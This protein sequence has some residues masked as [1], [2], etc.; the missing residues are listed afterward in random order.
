MSGVEK[1]PSKIAKS[2][3]QDFGDLY[4]RFIR[5]ALPDDHAMGYWDL[6]GCGTVSA[7]VPG[8]SGFFPWPFFR[9]H[10]VSV[11]VQRCARR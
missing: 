9:V 4:R 8:L 2:P 7:V 10:F 1:L 6:V 5:L 11:V 3:L